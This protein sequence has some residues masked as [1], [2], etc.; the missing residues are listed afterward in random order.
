MLMGYIATLYEL[1]RLLFNE[2]YQSASKHLLAEP[3]H[4]SIVSILNRPDNI[5]HKKYH[6]RIPHLSN[7]TFHMSTVF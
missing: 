5:R 2:Y 3:S 7:N 1:Q 6:Y 4:G